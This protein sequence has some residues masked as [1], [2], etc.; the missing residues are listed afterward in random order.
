MAAASSN[1]ATSGAAEVRAVEVAD[2]A[3]AETEFVWQILAIEGINFTLLDHYPDFV[4][5]LSLE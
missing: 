4:G 3:V 1:K 5:S 2:L